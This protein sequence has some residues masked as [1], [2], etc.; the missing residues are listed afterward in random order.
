[1]TKSTNP[2][3]VIYARSVSWDSPTQ[4]RAWFTLPTPKQLGTYTVIVTNPDGST[5]SLENGFEVK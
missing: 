5:C 4:V 2:N 1:M 3:I